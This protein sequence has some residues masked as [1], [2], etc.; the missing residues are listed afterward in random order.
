MTVESEIPARLEGKFKAMAGCWVLGLGSLIAWNS[1]LTIGDYYCNL[2]KTYHPTKPL[3]PVYQPFAL[4]T[5]AKAI[6]AYNEL[7]AEEAKQPEKLS[8]KQLL[9]QN[10]DYALDLFMIY[11]LTLSIFPK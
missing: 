3:T 4:I 5:I 9:L 2:F 8:T 11:V 7:K 6:L 1:M 10:I